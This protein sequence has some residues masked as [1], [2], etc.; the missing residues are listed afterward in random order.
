[1]DHQ[2]RAQAR[3]P[4]NTPGG[5]SPIIPGQQ[6]I[7]PPLYPAVANGARRA[8]AR[9]SLSEQDTGSAVPKARD[10]GEAGPVR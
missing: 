9:R 3:H 1:M 4:T 2:P 5:S 8:T 10:A 7:D 6:P